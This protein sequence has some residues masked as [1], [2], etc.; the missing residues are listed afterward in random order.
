M[1]APSGASRCLQ[2]PSGA[3]ESLQTPAPSGASR[4]LRLPSG[5]LECVQMPSVDC[6]VLAGS[7]GVRPILASRLLLIYPP[8]SLQVGACAGRAKPTRT[9]F[10]PPI[11]M[12]KTKNRL[13]P[14]KPTPTQARGFLQLPS[15]RKHHWEHWEPR[16]GRFADPARLAT[17]P[18]LAPTLYTTYPTLAPTLH[19][20]LPYTCTYPIY[21][22][23]LHVVA[24]L[25]CTS[26]PSLHL[27]LP[28]TPTYLHAHTTNGHKH[29]KRRRK[30]EVDGVLLQPSRNW[31]RKKLSSS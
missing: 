20:R 11:C 5:A 18:I 23:T 10:A 6:K 27:R 25:P 24:D 9:I 29:R 15:A 28:Y 4:C 2:L 19:L 13:P 1:P 12:A 14:H 22:P 30:E 8:T 7:I 26:P 17:Y 31:L 16:N 21:R 3:L